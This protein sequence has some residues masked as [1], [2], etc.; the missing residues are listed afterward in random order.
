[1]KVSD[2]NHAAD[3]RDLCCTFVIC[4]HVEFVANFP[5]ALS[6]TKFHYSDTNRFVA[7]LSRTLL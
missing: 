5:R 1:M 2:T 6:Q 7:D 3:F 4:V